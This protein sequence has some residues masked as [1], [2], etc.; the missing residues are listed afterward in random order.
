MQPSQSLERL[1]NEYPVMPSLQLELG[2]T[3]YRLSNMTQHFGPTR[4]PKP[5]GTI[6][7]AMGLRVTLDPDDPVVGDFP[8]AME[9]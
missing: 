8:D 3:G 4:D 5:M 2:S 1:L 7:F 6:A 9:A